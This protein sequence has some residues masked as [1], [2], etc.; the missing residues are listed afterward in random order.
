MRT[1]II[2][3]FA[4]LFIPT[5]PSTPAKHEYPSKEQKYQYCMSIKN[6]SRTCLKYAYQKEK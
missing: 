6:D 2:I 5:K 1:I 3:I 4:L